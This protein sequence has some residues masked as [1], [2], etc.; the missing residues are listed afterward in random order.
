MQQGE[1]EVTEEPGENFDPEFK[2]ELS[3]KELLELGIFGGKYMTDC[4]DEFP[5]DWFENAKLSP[6]K[7]DVSSNHYQVDA[8]H[9]FKVVARKSLDPSR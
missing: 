5:A 1:Y 7:T 6:G 8:C 9:V 2:P 3:P 4:T